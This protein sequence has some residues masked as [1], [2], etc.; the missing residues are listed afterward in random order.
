MLELILAGEAHHGATHYETFEKC[1]FLLEFKE[2]DN[3]N[4]RNTLSISRIELKL[5]FVQNVETDPSTIFR[6]YGAGT[7][8][9]QIGLF[10]K[11]S[12]CE[13]PFW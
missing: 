3:F 2:D 5:H 13:Y 10:C 6:S 4:R 8:I 11:V 12:C 9:G 7:E 1:Q